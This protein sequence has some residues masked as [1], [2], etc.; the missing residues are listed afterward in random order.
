PV[1]GV[2]KRV[3]SYTRPVYSD[4]AVDYT[5]TGTIRSKTRS[6]KIKE[7]VTRVSHPAPF[8][9]AKAV[10]GDEITTLSLNDYENKFLVMVFYP[11]DFTFVCPTELLAFSDRLEEFQAINTEVVGISCDS[12]HSHFAWSKLPRKLGGIENI[13]IP[14]V[15]D[16]SKKITEEYNVLFEEKGIPLR[17]TVIIDDKGIVRVININDTEIGRSV[18]EVLRLVKAIQFANKHGEVCPVNWKEGDATIVP[19]QKKSKEYF[20][21]M[22]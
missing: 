1:L 3:L 17:A 14:L 20:S 13:R 19:D 21:S 6:R 2:S 7:N 18:D 16:Y 4:S 9:E 5:A 22:N 8:W 10:V 11:F 15:A 12:E